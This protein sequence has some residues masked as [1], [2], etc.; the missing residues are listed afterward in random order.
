[1]ILDPGTLGNN[2]PVALLAHGRLFPGKQGWTI[3]GMGVVTGSTALLQST[4]QDRFALGRINMAPEAEI[5]AWL[6]KEP[7]VI[8]RVGIM[9]GDAPVFHGRMNSLHTGGRII[10]AA[11]AKLI[12]LAQQKPGGVGAVHAMAGIALVSLQRFVDDLAFRLRIMALA[13]Q[14]R[15]RL[16]GQPPLLP[17]MGI[18][19]FGAPVL[20][21]FVGKLPAAGRIIVTLQTQLLTLC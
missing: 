12:T 13:T 11:K 21:S 19:A 7:G 15:D 9:T 6:P 10:M 20:D 16:T 17:Q 8:R 5:I 3:G 1:V 2:L 4:V 14:G 18:M